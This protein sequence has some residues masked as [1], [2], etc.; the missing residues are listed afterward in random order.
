MTFQALT[1]ISLYYTSI[2]CTILLT[3]GF[4]SL[5]ECYQ[6]SKYQYLDFVDRGS[7]KLPSDIIIVACVTLYKYLCY[8]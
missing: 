3:T 7:L 4:E 1:F 6:D 8:D 5:I 2:L